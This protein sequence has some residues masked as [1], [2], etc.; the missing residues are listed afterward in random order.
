[1]KLEAPDYLSTELSE[2][3]DGDISSYR[4]PKIDAPNYHLYSSWVIQDTD[5]DMADMS[6]PD[7]LKERWIIP[8]LRYI[9]DEIKKFDVGLFAPLQT[10]EEI[11]PLDYETSGVLA[12]LVDGTI[13]VRWTVAYTF[14][15][16]TFTIDVLADLFMKGEHE[17][18]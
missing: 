14:R 6:N 9:A 10:S 4:V 5:E 13:P 8:A 11:L 12:E 17:T 3:V 2:M 16:W 7:K 1:M 18:A 15:G